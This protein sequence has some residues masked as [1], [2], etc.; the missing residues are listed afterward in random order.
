[1]L[2]HTEILSLSAELGSGGDLKLYS[3]DTICVNAFTPDSP[4]FIILNYN[5]YIY[6]CT[7]EFSLSFSCVT[8]FIN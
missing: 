8:L 6:Q 7:V 4:V 1:M 3:D 5:M 2:I